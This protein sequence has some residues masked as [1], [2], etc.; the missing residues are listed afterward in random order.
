MAYTTHEDRDIN[1]LESIL[2]EV[3]F[4]KFTALLADQFWSRIFFKILFTFLSEKSNTPLWLKTLPPGIMIC[5]NVH[6]NLQNL[7][8]LSHIFQLFWP[9]GF[10]N[11]FWQFRSICSFV[12][13]RSSTV[14]QPYP[15]ES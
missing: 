11:F 8:M 12:K 13:I 2:Y 5:T 14:A 6:V 4:T 9:N 1:R 7:R 10:C 15:R 3:A